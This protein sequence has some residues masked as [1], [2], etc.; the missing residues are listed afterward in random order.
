V[1]LDRAPVRIANIGAGFWAAANHLP[2]LRGRQDVKLVSVCGLPGSQLDAVGREFGFDLVT[3]NVDEALDAGVDAV[4]VTSPNSFHYEHAVKALERG[5]HLLIEKPLGVTAEQ[6]WDLVTLAERTGVHALV[7]YGWNYKRFT[8]YAFDALAQGTLGTVESFVCQMASPTIDLFEGRGDYGST[9]VSGIETRAG[10]GTWADP[11]RGGGYGFGQLT[12]ALGLLFWL[13]DLDPASVYGQV[14]RSGT[15]ADVVD[16]AVLTLSNGAVGTVTGNARLPAGCG[17][18]LDIRIFGD[19]G[20][21]FLDVE[22]E[23]CEIH[24]RSG[25]SMVYPCAPGDGAY[26]CVEPV[27]RFVDLI[28]GQGVRNQSPLACAARAVTVVD[29]L[30]TSDATGSPVSLRGAK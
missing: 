13:V 22:R 26:E 24:L 4:V 28:T 7:P 17:F 10:A 15:D 6:A 3:S 2:Q 9:V 21:L 27:H 12:H 19:R 11:S 23:R 8:E 29:G 5:M 30:L 1:T 14:R 18:Q 20:V 25:E 16:A